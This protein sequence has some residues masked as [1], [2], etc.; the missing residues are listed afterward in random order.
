M[1]FLTNLLNRT[2][3]IETLVIILNNVTNAESL[4]SD[5][6]EDLPLNPIEKL[7]NVS[8]LGLIGKFQV[9]QIKT[10]LAVCDGTLEDLQIDGYI[11]P[12]SHE[13]EEPQ[14]IRVVDLLGPDRKV[15]QITAKIYLW[16]ADDMDYF[17]Q[18][19]L[20]SSGETT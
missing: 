4:L 1:N 17:F 7:H 13:G 5:L 9:H 6:D 19:Y 20:A 3:N 11:V 15:R 16:S 2:P 14:R 8:K 12:E 10:I 18:D